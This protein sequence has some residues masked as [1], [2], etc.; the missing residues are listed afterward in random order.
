MVPKW[1]SLEKH[2]QGKG[3]MNK[4][5]S[6]WISNVFMEKM[7]RCNELVDNATWFYHSNVCSRKGAMYTFFSLS[8]KSSF[9]LK[10]LLILLNFKWK[11]HS[12]FNIFHIWCLKITKLPLNFFFHWK[13]RTIPNMWSSFLKTKL[14]VLILL[15][16][17]WMFNIH[18]TTN[19]HD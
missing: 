8:L 9:H 1:D 7:K 14:L 3:R 16:F 6:L 15:K 12:K 19:I 2:V 11:N 17:Q 13:L 4:E 18:F 10:K 5:W